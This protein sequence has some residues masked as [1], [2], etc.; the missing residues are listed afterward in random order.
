M[1][2]PTGTPGN[3]TDLFKYCQPVAKKDGYCEASHSGS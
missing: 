2:D 1:V 3:T